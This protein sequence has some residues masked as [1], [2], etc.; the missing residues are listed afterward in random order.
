[1]Q[2]LS[3]VLPMGHLN[4]GMSAVLVRGQGAEA[5]GAPIAL[6][7]GFT[8]VIGAIAARVFRWESD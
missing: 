2:T 4:S 1:M 7:L 5:I 3:R 6:L 8:L